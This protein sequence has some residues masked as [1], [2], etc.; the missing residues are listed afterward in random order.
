MNFH[1]HSCLFAGEVQSVHLRTYIRICLR[2]VLVVHP[3]QC[4]QLVPSALVL[5]HFVSPFCFT[6]VL[7]SPLFF[8]LYFSSDLLLQAW[9]TNR[10]QTAEA[11]VV[12]CVSD[13]NEPPRWPRSLYVTSVSERPHI[14]TEI[15]HLVAEDDDSG[16][17][18]SQMNIQ[19]L[20]IR[21][22]LTHYSP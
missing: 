1:I 21:K 11:T 22:H 12:V 17:L 3:S 14:E 15:Y 2:R 13:V 19:H 9:H 20:H 4:S 7:F 8:L 16:S 6:F 5:F 10:T 18:V